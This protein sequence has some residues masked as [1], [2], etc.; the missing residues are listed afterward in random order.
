MPRATLDVEVDLT[1][2]GD[3]TYAVTAAVQVADISYGREDELD[4][5]RGGRL[6]LTFRYGADD[7]D[8]LQTTTW[9]QVDMGLV[10]GVPIRIRST[11][12]VVKTLFVGFITSRSIDPS[13]TSQQIQINAV[14]AMV[15]IQSIPVSL[16]LMTDE[17]TGTII[18]RILD[19]AEGVELCREPWP[20]DSVGNWI[21]VASG[22]RT[23]ATTGTLLHAPASMTITMPGA[24]DGAETTAFISGTSLPGLKCTAAVYLRPETTADDGQKVVLSLEDSTGA[25][26]TSADTVLVSSSWTRVSVTGTF[27][28]EGATQS[29]RVV[30]A[31]AGGAGSV[32]LGAVHMVAAREAIPRSIDRGLSAIPYYGPFRRNA[33]ECLDEVQSGELGGYLYIDG[34]GTA[35]FEE[36]SSR[37]SAATSLA[38]IDDTMSGLD[39]EESLDDRITKVELSYGLYEIGVDGTVLWSLEMTQSRAIPASGT[40]TI[41]APLGFL[42]KNFITTLVSGVQQLVANTDW[43]ANSKPDGTGTDQ[44]GN[45]VMTLEKFG[46]GLV[47]SMENQTAVEIWLTQLAVRGTP[48]RQG[49]DMPLYEYTPAI[50]AYVPN[51]LVFD[52]PLNDSAIAVESW[53]AYLGDRYSRQQERLSVTLKPSSTAQLTTMLQRVLSDRVTIINDTK[54]YASMV[55]GDYYIENITHRIQKGAFLHDTM[56]KLIPVIPTV[57]NLI[58]NPSAETDITGI[59]SPTLTL[60]QDGTQFKFGTKSVKATYTAAATEKIEWK[61]RDGSR[62]P[63]T[64][65]KQYTW[66]FYYKPAGSLAAGGHAGIRW[67]NSGGSEISHPFGIGFLT[68]PFSLRGGADWARIWM[69]ARAPS[70]AV[71]AVPNFEEST[72]IG[73]GEI[74]FFDGAMFNDGGLYP[75]G[76][77]TQ[78]GWIWSGTAQVST[79][80]NYGTFWILEDAT[81]GVLDVRTKLAP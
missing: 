1:G 70:N 52:Y 43:R 26:V 73:A 32:R 19:T 22:T 79:S 65:N 3:F 35:V 76:D 63:V 2:V 55:N 53:G 7:P 46:E 60:A 8:L 23:L 34:T 67:Y 61:N 64:G 17:W 15:R 30:R 69:S 36:Q 44:T 57:T 51:P 56:W 54:R 62:I 25:I 12:P 29:I 37:F 9:R 58:E 14:D 39:Y 4:H 48:I 78:A 10:P 77:G 31:S 45:V 66:S 41:Q 49:S 24:G 42:A 38:T 81:F 20:S 11:S 27:A 74:I 5:S 75:Y 68:A 40:L 6:N 16:G 13:P 72:T 18:N 80:I 33:G 71:T 50:T 47:I 59:S 28:L 21:N